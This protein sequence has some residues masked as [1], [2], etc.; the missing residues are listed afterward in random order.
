MGKARQIIGE[1]RLEVKLK[2]DE[3]Q[4]HMETSRGSHLENTNG[5][6]TLA[7]GFDDMF[8]NRFTMC[9]DWN[10]KYSLLEVKKL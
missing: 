5:W 4:F 6:I 9:L 2:E 1:W 7:K 3:I 10:K 8:L